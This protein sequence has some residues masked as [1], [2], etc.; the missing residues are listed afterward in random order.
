MSTE[1]HRDRR[2]Q[3]SRV[4]L[5]NAPAPPQRIQLMI[6]ILLAHQR[7]ICEYHS[8]T[9]VMHFNKQSLDVRLTH[10]LTRS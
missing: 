9:I 7:E 4:A 8:G 3:S 10:N 1:S 5:A 6:E 2:V